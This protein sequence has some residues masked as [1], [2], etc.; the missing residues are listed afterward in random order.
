[1]ETLKT[2]KQRNRDWEE[3]NPTIFKE[4]GTTAEC[5]TFI[6]GEYLKEKKEKEK[7]VTYLK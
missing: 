6:S 2:E 4:Q 3:K 1:M 5:G 7:Q